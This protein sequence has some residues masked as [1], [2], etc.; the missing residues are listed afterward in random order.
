MKTAY[1]G[2]SK[3]NRVH[4]DK[5]IQQLKKSL[6]KHSIELLVFV[7]KYEFKL[8]EEKKMMTIAF[9]EIDK[10]DFL[11][12]ELTKKAI[13]VG[14]EVGYAVAKQK[15]IIYIKRKNAN[16]STTVSGC[17]DFS[18]EYENEVHLSEE[19]EKLI[20]VLQF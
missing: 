14:V 8:G 2:I 18:I 19:I 1:F 20:K 10:S 12:V 9:E 6:A 17:S 15:P 11:I 13:G 3:S 5:E 4:F 7:D 16:H